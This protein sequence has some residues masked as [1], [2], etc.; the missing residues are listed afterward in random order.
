MKSVGWLLLLLAPLVVGASCGVGF[1]VGPN[2]LEDDDDDN[3]DDDDDDNGD[4]DD[5][6]PTGDVTLTAVSPSSG[7]MT[8]GYDAKIFGTNFAPPAQTTVYF[9]AAVAPVTSCESNECIVTVPPAGASGPV[10]VSLENPNGVGILTDGFTYVEDMSDQVSY[11]LDLYRVEYLCPDCYDPP[12]ATPTYARALGYFFEP[13]AI[14][15]YREVNWGGLLPAVGNCV[16]YSEADWTTITIT[17][18]DAGTAVGLSGAG[19]VTLNKTDFY[20]DSGELPSSSYAAGLYNLEIPGGSDLGAE[21]VSSSLLAPAPVQVAPAMNPLVI[22]PSDLNQ[23]LAVN[24]QGA[25]SSSVLNLDAIDQSGSGTLGS[26]LCHYGGA[27]PMAVPAAYVTPFSNALAFVATVECYEE[28]LTVVNSGAS[29]SGVG[30][31]AAL[32]VIFLQ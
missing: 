28:T 18:Y 14:D 15:V 16:S 32:G 23:G 21:T 3:S 30:R 20:Y 9:G 27:G 24:M 6:T 12:I 7:P 5:T 19:S 29:M 13:D 31:S 2:G 26:V 11:S 4:D 17:A 1:P 10:Q 22:S 25:C 8:G